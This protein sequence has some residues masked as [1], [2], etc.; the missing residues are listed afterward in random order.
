MLP[1]APLFYPTGP[2]P[3]PPLDLSC[4]RPTSPYICP[5]SQVCKSDEL[6][7]PSRGIEMK[8]DLPAEDIT[9]H[10]LPSRG[11]GGE[12]I[13]RYSATK[14]GWRQC[15]RCSENHHWNKK[16]RLASGVMLKACGHKGGLPHHLDARA[17]PHDF[18]IAYT[19]I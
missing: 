4:D 13:E 14:R 19:S 7:N 9:G 5:Q 2:L 11:G 8:V 16:C 3:S 1:S 6:S 18:P 10:Q 12:H 15:A 17:H